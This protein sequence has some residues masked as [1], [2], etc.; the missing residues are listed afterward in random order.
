MP[1]LSYEVSVVIVNWNGAAVLPR[2]LEHLQ[3]QTYDNFETIVVDNASTD[4]SVD[5]LEDEYPGLR[6]IRL[7]ENK[8]FAAANNIGAGHA[9]GKWLALLNNDAFPEPKWLGNLVHAAETQPEFTFFGS[10][11]IQDRQPQ[12]LDG[13]GDVYHVSG[14]AWREGYN[15]P[16]SE[17]DLQEME[18]FSPTAAAALYSRD[19]FLEIGGFTEWFYMY[20]ED[21]DLGFRLRLRGHRCLFVPDAVARHVGSASTAVKS[22]F[23]VYHG[24][25]NLVWSYWLNMPGRLFW[26]YL[27][28]HIFMNLIFTGYYILRGQPGPILRA[29]WNAFKE[30]PQVLK[31]RKAVQLGRVA[32][33][34][35][36]DRVMEHRW[37]KPYLLGYQARHS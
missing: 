10:K 7:D 37:F 34:G 30:I 14:V 22:D 4:G 18:I 21:V 17:F 2:C 20:H 26:K 33:V 8:G 35:E 29:K 15:R 23:A 11:L 16:E 31:K 3:A 25:R 9:R 19:A 28:A 36:I 13:I 27:P 6:V 1:S 24:H 12:I 32:T 5:H